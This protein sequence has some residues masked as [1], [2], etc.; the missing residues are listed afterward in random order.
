MPRLITCGD[1][2]VASLQE[3]I[4]Q[5]DTQ[6]FDPRDDA[7]LANAAVALRRLANN[8]EFLGN[9]M[10]EQLASGRSEPKESGVGYG[11]QSMVL[12]GVGNGYFLR[13]NIWPSERDAILAASGSQSFVYGVPHDHNFSFLTVGYFGPGYRSRYYEYDYAS[14]VGNI[15]EKPELRFIEESALHEG[16]M[17]LYRAHLDIHDQIPPESLSVS[18]N[19]MQADEVSGWFD[20]YSFDLDT[21][22]ITG[23]INPNATESFLRIAVG[24]GGQEAFDLAERFGR[25]HPSERIRLACFEARSGMLETAAARDALWT[26][27]ENNG[28]LRVARAATQ[29]RKALELERA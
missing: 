23:L 12:S 16:K 14:V 9:L 27:A 8:R 7:S 1:T 2:G 5:L 28:S 25:T 19:V 6:L 20:Q 10:I 26:A 17:Q 11:P 29:Q 3:A 22:E 13:A 15:G 21:G 18:I 24:L 4:E